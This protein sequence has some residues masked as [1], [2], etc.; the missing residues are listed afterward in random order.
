MSWLNDRI[1]NRLRTL[2]QDPRMAVVIDQVKANAKPG[3]TSDE[4]LAQAAIAARDS[5]AREGRA[6]HADEVR[7]RAFLAAAVATTEQPTTLADLPAG[8]DKTQHFFMSGWLSLQIARVADVVLPRSLAQQVGYGLSMALGYAKEVYD[9]FVGSG[10]NTE[11]LKADRA[12]ARSPFTVRV[13][14]AGGQKAIGATK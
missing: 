10:Y 5:F 7:E 6:P 3:V 14:G 4:L 2:R 1:E 8:N 12:G 9:Q 13:P 11:D